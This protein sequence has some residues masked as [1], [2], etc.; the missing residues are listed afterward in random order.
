[1]DTNTL[2]KKYWVITAAARASHLERP[3]SAN[4]HGNAR[5]ESGLKRNHP[6][7]MPAQMMPGSSYDAL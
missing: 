1:M 4:A 7:I 6:Q 2:E 5:I 3:F